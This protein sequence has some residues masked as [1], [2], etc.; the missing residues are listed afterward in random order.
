MNRCN[1]AVTSGAT[2]ITLH[3]PVGSEQ[4][5]GAIIAIDL[6]L[7]R[8]WETDGVDTLT[9]VERG[10]NSSVAA[11]HS[12]GAFVEVIPKFS[13]FRVSQSINEDLDDLCSPTTAC[14]PCRW[15]RWTSPTTR[16]CG[17]TT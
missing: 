3:Y 14:S 1:G 4:I 10:V 2:S 12:D 15:G 17:A 11:S 6:E 7:I 16:P 8:V 9:V 5:R 13:Q